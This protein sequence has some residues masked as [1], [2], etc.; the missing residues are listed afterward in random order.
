MRDI[1]KKVLALLF[2]VLLFSKGLCKG[3]YHSIE[4]VLKNNDAV[5]TWTKSH[6]KENLEKAVNLLKRSIAV[7]STYK[8]AYVN[9]AQCLTML[10]KIE[11]AIEIIAVALKYFPDDAY[12]CCIQGVL[13][14]K[15]H[16]KELSNVFF[17]KAIVLIEKKIVHTISDDLFFM[18]SLTRAFCGDRCLGYIELLM[19]QSSFYRITFDLAKWDFYNI[20]LKNILNFDRNKEI[21]E[22]WSLS[23]P[24]SERYVIDYS[25]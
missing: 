11:R 1:D 18:K 22:Y 13:L 9:M 6:N 5:E 2:V 25:R 14:A 10:N 4:A 3:Q 20:E 7:D 8:I 17:Q 23:I 15:L 21:R 19:A 16:K 12:L 24:E